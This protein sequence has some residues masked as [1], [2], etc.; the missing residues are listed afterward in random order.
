MQDRVSEMLTAEIGECGSSGALSEC[1]CT[2]RPAPPATTSRVACGQGNGVFGGLNCW[3]QR[4][5]KSSA[6]C[7]MPWRSARTCGLASKYACT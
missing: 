7:L 1:E 4:A 5:R 2:I 6:G 3:L